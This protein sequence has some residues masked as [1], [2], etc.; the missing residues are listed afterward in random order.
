M[1]DDESVPGLHD[2]RS[3]PKAQRIARY[4]A[5]LREW[6]DFE[7]AVHIAAINA[8]ALKDI[9]DDLVELKNKM[10]P[11]RGIKESIEEAFD[12]GQ[13]GLEIGRRSTEKLMV[14]LKEKIDKRSSLSSAGVKGAQS[15]HRPMAELKEW[16]LSEANRIRGSHKDIARNLT[17]RIPKHLVNV[18]K[19]PERLIYDTLRAATQTV[20]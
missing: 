18:S 5:H 8:I 3:V 6:V 7:L 19:D 16:A 12:A 13:E 15:L 10:E 20:T 1:D 4:E 2:P 14:V 9:E 11:L 17:S